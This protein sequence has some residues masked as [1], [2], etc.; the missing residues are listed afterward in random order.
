MSGSKGG[1]A[2]LEGFEA[3]AQAN[4]PGMSVGEAF[5][6]DSDED[7]VNNGFEYAFGTNLVS[8]APLLNVLQVEGTFV[9]DIPRQLSG[10]APYVSVYLQMARTLDNPGW[11]TN[12]IEAVTHAQKPATRSWYKPAQALTNGFF[13][14]R[15]ELL[16]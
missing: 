15:G 14:L 3:W 9:V 1:G 2:A 10:T 13:C 12:G 4:C 6:A 16:Q 8:N 5:V 7:G 11:S